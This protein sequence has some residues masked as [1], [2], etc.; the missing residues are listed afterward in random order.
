MF[1]TDFFFLDFSCVK[2]SYF[3]QWKK[4]KGE[5]YFRKDH[6]VKQTVLLPSEP[7]KIYISEKTAGQEDPILFKNPRQRKW[8]HIG[9][10]SL[11]Y[12]IIYTIENYRIKTVTI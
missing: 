6:S 3:D 12:Q 9:C 8:A 7:N 2:Y 1:Q 11:A 4:K 5:G 10:T